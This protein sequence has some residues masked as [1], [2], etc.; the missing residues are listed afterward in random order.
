MINCETDI[1]IFIDEQKS[2]IKCPSKVEYRP[3]E[4]SEE[5]KRQKTELI[6]KIN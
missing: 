6:N 2:D 1:K 3:Y 5:V 4:H